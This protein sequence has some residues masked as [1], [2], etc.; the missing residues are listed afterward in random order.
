[1]LHLRPQVCP[2]KGADMLDEEAPLETFYE[3]MS[4]LCTDT[5]RLNAMRDANQGQVR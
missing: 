3:R 2:R 4:A 5:L 1:M